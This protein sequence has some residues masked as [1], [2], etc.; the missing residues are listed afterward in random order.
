MCSGKILFRLRCYHLWL[1]FWPGTIFAGSN[2]P[3]VNP[4]YFVRTQFSYPGLSDLSYAWNFR[5]VTDR[6]GFFDLLCTFR[7]HFIFVWKPPRTKYTKITCIRNI[8][9]SIRLFK[10][11]SVPPPPPP[12]PFSFSKKK[13]TKIT[14]RGLQP[15]DECRSSWHAHTLAKLSR[16]LIQP[17]FFFFFTLNFNFYIQKLCLRVKCADRK[18]FQML[19][20]SSLFLDNKRLF[21]V[22]P[23]PVPLHLFWW[24][25]S[26]VHLYFP[27][28]TL[29][30]I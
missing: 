8:L 2:L 21:S 18:R 13:T 27:G 29:A 23:V 12:Q 19:T 25:C 3:A 22:L 11:S 14:T 10:R 9:D 7:M 1:L 16:G 15:C 4:E 17:F 6:C 20:S 28:S 26:S 24:L 30:F 5:T